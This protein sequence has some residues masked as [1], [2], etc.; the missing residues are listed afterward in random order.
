MSLSLAERL[1][2]ERHRRFVG[3]TRE[4]NLFQE[5]IAAAKLPFNVLHLFGPGGIGKTAL[6][7]E[8]TRICQQAQ[9]PITH[10]DARNIEPAPESFLSALRFAMGLPPLSSPLQG[11]TSQ[12]NR[13]VVL[14]DTYETFATL[15][16]WLRQVFLPQL[17]ENILVVLGGR[18]SPGSAWRADPG[19]QALI[20]LLSLRNLSPEE[21]RIYLQMRR[22]VPLVQHQ[23][24]LNFTHGHPLALSLVAD[25]FGQGQH[26]H[27]QPAAVPDVV[28]TLLEK[29]MQK[30]PSTDHRRAL[31]ACALARITTGALLA[32]MLAMPDAHELFEWLRKLSFIESGHVGIFLHDLAREVIIAELRWRDPDWYI[33]LHSRARTYYTKRLAQTQGQE[34][35][36]ILFDYIFLHRDN[37]S[38]RPYFTWQESSGLSTDMLRETDLPVLVEMVA[39]HEGEASARLATH[40]LT[41]Q[42]QGV[43][44]FRNA[45]QQPAGF[46]SMVALHLVSAEDFSIDPAVC[47]AGRYLQEH[48][49][50]RPGEGA[51]LLRFWMARDT[52]QAVS[53]IQSLLFVNLIQH[54]RSGVGPA[55]TFFMCAEPDFWAQIFGYADLARIPEADFKVGDHCY[56]VY[57]HDWRVVSPKVWQALL[58]QREIDASAQAMAVSGKQDGSTTSYAHSARATMTA[59]SLIGEPLV[60]LSQTEFAEAVRD[61]LRNFSRTS[62]LQGNPLLQSRLVVERVAAQASKAERIV[63]LQNTLQEAADSLQSAPREA[64][65]YRALYHTYLSPAPTHEQA[66]DLLSLPL[67][68]FRRHLKMGVTRMID[69]LWQQEI[70]GEGL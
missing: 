65:Q 44:V 19:W 70:G 35:Q 46:V 3:R 33:E 36:H 22:E 51:T 34:Q 20:H 1:R 52:Y 8:F 13:H 64:K 29:F 14:I 68:T 38:V 26:I 54:H 45:D 43:L 30:A 32:E 5:A 61:A 56:G 63:V 28:K 6:L 62:T 18:H 23:A 69:I 66:A 47:L 31:E 21:S 39:Q 17:G 25:V 9:I 15:D 16:E 7:W 58:A 59:P 50:L 24:I 67:S 42:P 60:V 10:L 37:P 57:G 41:R 12:P 11:L 4:L 27:F 2:T 40:W 49:P 55:F 53:P 48:A